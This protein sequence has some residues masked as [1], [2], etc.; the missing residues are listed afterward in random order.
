[1]R[2]V[3]LA[4]S[5]ILSSEQGVS[6]K[7]WRRRASARV[8]SGQASVPREVEL[9]ARRFAGVQGEAIEHAIRVAPVR[10]C[11]TSSLH[12]A[13]QPSRTPSLPVGT[14]QAWAKC[15]AAPASRPSS[16]RASRDAAVPVVSVLDTLW[17]A[18]LASLV[19]DGIHG[20]A[21]AESLLNRANSAALPSVCKRRPEPL[22][23][24]APRSLGRLQAVIQGSLARL[25]P[26]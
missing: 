2:A 25:R 3:A 9:A 13:M 22:E 14:R 15:A 6:R 17:A 11:G 19:R 21:A 1:M 16:A 7:R 12:N 26:S 4:I 5:E 8:T 24:A 18:F 10:R 20:A 23:A